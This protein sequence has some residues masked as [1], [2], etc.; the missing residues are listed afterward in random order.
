MSSPSR[1]R[2]EQLIMLLGSMF[3]LSDTNTALVASATKR[4][5]DSKLMSCAVPP[6]RRSELLPLCTYA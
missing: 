1:Y 4:D 2:S 5:I 6:S 3:I